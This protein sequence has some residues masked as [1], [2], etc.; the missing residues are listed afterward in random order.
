METARK[1]AASVRFWCGRRSPSAMAVWPPYVPCSRGQC[2]PPVAR[3]G[4]AATWSSSRVH[5]RPLPRS[6][7]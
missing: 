7:H 4:S 2:L 5:S 1:K 3:R 6:R